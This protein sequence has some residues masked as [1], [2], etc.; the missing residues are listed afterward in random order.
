LTPSIIPLLQATK[1]AS[2][3]INHLP[4]ADRIAITKK[5]ALS[6]EENIPEIIAANKKDLLKLDPS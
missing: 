4:D 1:T 5:L 3:K 6:I 2:K